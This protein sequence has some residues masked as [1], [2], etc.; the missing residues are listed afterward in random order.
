MDKQSVA[1]A[2]NRIPLNNKKELGIVIHVPMW[3]CLNIYGMSKKQ[4]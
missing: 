4:D 2:N 3:M 1:Y